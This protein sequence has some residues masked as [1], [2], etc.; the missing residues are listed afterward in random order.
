MSRRHSLWTD[1]VQEPSRSVL[2]STARRNLPVGMLRA[3]DPEQ[4]M[5]QAVNWLK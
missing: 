5:R 2:A 4:R 1:S 3:Q